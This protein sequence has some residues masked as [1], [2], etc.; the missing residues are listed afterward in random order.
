MVASPRL[1]PIPELSLLLKKEKGPIV[2]LVQINSREKWH[3]V[4][5]LCAV[6][7]E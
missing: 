5:F 4:Q 3:L 1:P 7:S 2:L 6:L